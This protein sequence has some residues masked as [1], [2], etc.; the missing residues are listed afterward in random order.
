MGLGLLECAAGRRQ[1]ASACACVQVVG[2]QQERQGERGAQ[3]TP[4][5]PVRWPHPCSPMYAAIRLEPH[6]SGSIDCCVQWCHQTHGVVSR[7][8]CRV[9]RLKPLGRLFQ[10]GAQ[11]GHGAC[12]SEAGIGRKTVAPPAPAAVAAAVPRRAAAKAP[13]CW[14]RDAQPPL[15]LFNS[16]QRPAARARPGLWSESRQPAEAWA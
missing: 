7:A 8:L 5:H 14:Q 12:T 15:H 2:F 10:K 16:S 4:A 1:P 6:S 11:V 3:A 9:Q 13:A